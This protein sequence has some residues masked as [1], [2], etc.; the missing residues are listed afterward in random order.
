M[1]GVVERDDGGAS[2]CPAGDLHR[3]LDR[4]GAR[5]HEDRALLPAAARRE[6][7]QPLADLDVR[8]VDADHEALVQVPV[9]LLL[10]RLDDGRV[11]VAGVLAADAAGEVDVRAPVGVGDPSALGVRDDE[12]RRRHPG[13]D[14]ASAVGEDPL[15]C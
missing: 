13:S 9:R 15:R 4:L 7:R 3:V 11:A 6:L 14:V 8:L 2:G 10:D 12:L 5:V 1:E